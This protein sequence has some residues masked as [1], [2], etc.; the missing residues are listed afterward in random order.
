M[1]Q[2]LLEL[3]PRRTSYVVGSWA[4]DPRQAAAEVA[5]LRANVLKAVADSEEGCKLQ[6][7][8]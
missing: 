3:T 6:Q 1:W 8:M 5:H 7:S 4:A 2:A